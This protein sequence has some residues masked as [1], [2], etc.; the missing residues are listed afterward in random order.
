MNIRGVELRKWNVL[1]GAAL[2]AITGCGTE[3]ASIGASSDLAVRGGA[4][5]AD[6]DTGG[7]T[8]S[9][10]TR[11]MLRTPDTD[12]VAQFT[13][14]LKSRDFSDAARLAAM[15][16]TPQAVWFT[17]GSPK[18]VETA[19]R[20]TMRQADQQGRVPVLVAYNVP[21][22]DCAQYSAGGAA[23]TAS[24]KAWID[25]FARGIGSS[26]AVV[27]L[28]PDSL[29]II[30]YNTTIYGAAD[31]CKPTVTN[32]DGSVSPAP[33]ASPA[34][35]YAQINYA[36]D[37]LEGKASRALVYLDGTHSAWLGVGEAAYRLYTA[38]VQRSQGFFVDVSNYETTGDNTQ[39]GTWVSDCI[40]AATAGASWAAG[41]FDWCPSQYDPSQNY[42]LNYSPDYAAT[43][44]ASLANMLGGATATTHFVIDTSRNGQGP[45][46]PTATY[47]DPQ[48][49]CNPPGRGLGVV[50]TAS[51]GVPLL[52]AY[53]WVKTPGE[54]DGSCNR[55]VTG[56]TTDPEWSGIVDPA[57]G[58]WFPQQALQLAALASPALL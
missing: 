57:A 12:A 28:E 27:I 17:S 16:T 14:L 30:P 3:E 10:N 37:S 56:A 47:P 45:W 55:G 48:T 15:E 36:V 4:G 43:V 25:G 44:T 35:R 9:A 41:H 38:G 51:T 24:Y 6:C 11:F 26:K 58:A 34:E 42:A 19:V 33:G 2:I 53:L 39:F 18:D 7:R 52:D 5:G 13:S 21:F 8:L 40:T 1:W 46:H 22:R 54:S 32:A 50:P 20:K 31:W 23:D 49:W 29:G